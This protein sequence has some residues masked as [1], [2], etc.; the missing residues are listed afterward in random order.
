MLVK[1]NHRILEYAK[2]EGIHQDH[3]IR[4]LTRLSPRITPCYLPERVVQML[5]ELDR[6]G[7]VSPSLGYLFQCP[8]ILS[9]KTFS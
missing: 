4:L 6:C 2:L 7:A 9:V 5:L 3:H 1:L 8:N